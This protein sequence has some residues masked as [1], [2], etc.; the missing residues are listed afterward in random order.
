VN[1]EAAMT[2]EQAERSIRELR[3]IKG[4][5]FLVG[6]MLALLAGLRLGEAFSPRDPTAAMQSELSAIRAELQLL[7]TELQHHRV[8]PAPSIIIPPVKKDEGK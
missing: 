3:G 5:V 2:D 1:Q 6:V 8:P 7:R 4:G